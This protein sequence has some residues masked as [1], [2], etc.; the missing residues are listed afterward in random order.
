MINKKTVFGL[1]Y[2]YDGNRNPSCSYKEVKHEFP[3]G[4][5]LRNG[6]DYHIYDSEICSYVEIDFEEEAGSSSMVNV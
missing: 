4:S 1:K 5:S 6:H 3:A 2:P